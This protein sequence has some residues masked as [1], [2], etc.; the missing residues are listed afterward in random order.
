MSAPAPAPAASIRRADL[1]DTQDIAKL[2]KRCFD[3]AWD[4]QSIAVFLASPECL[5]LNAERAEGRCAG[6]LLTRI[7]ADEAELLTIAVAPEQ[8]REGI[9]K[10][11]MQA[12]M[13]GLKARGVATLFLEVD[14]KNTGAL[15][16]Y[17]SLGA[18]PVGERPG[19]YADGGDA[20]IFSLAL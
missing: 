10:A 18:A 9:A 15:A 16:L 8:R 17:E 3:P 13:E 5:C 20:A 7:A 12:A 19:Y 11:M 4:A 6:F 1:A 2:H 14:T